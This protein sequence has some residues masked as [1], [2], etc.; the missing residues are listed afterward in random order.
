MGDLKGQRQA[1]CVTRRSLTECPKR[2]LPKELSVS[3]HK[4]VEEVV[5]EGDMGLREG[6]CVGGLE[7]FAQAVAPLLI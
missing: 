7:V 2:T 1:K 5:V 4:L 6:L 3:G